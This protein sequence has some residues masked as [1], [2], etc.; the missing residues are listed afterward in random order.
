MNAAAR[1]R[2]VRIG[3]L[4]LGAGRPLVLIAGPCVIE[5][6]DGCMAI[7]DRLARWARREQVP[8]I[9]KASFD[10][11]NRSSLG[12]FRG[13]GAAE[14][15]EILQAVKQRHDVAVLTDIHEP[16]QAEAAAAVA[17]ILQIPAYLCRQTDLLVAA[18][19]TGRVVNIKKGQFLAPEDLAQVVAKVESTGNRKL[20]L[21]E[22]GTCF[23]YH[24]LVTDFRSLAILR[25][26]GHPVVFDA[27]H[28]VQRPGGLGDRSG[29]DGCWAPLLAR[30][31]VA[32][33][34]CDA[35]FFETHPDPSAALSD[36]ANMVPLGALP[37][38]WRQLVALHRVVQAPRNRKGATR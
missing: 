2:T 36:G 4:R 3:P 14:G 26:L 34:A 23:G 7:A 31:A 16:W 37:A 17:D 13:P 9:F 32:T 27:T 20:L 6:S 8:W 19:E 5:S 1:P 25:S 24:N 22:R 21:T 29:G 10:K 33:G 30:A 18:G 15:L 38:V 35:V 12:S 11:A 28:S